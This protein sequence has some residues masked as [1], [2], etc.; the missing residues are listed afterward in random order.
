MHRANRICVLTPG[1]LGSDPRVVKEAD[2][3]AEAGHQVTVIATRTL[4]QVDRLDEVV[5]ANATW[6]SRAMAVGRPHHF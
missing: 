1:P 2:A 6:R 3:L 4:D 5:L